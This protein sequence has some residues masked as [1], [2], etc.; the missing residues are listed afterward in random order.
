ME[1]DLSGELAKLRFVSAVNEIKYY[2]DQECKQVKS[3]CIRT[4]LHDLI[5][6]DK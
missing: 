1:G 2:V 5:N 3:E 4:I 6:N